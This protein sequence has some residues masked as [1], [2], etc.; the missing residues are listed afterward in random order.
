MKSHRICTH[1]LILT[2]LLTA[3]R[4]LAADA[5]SLELIQTIVLKGKAGK[6]DHLGL[7]ASASGCSWRTP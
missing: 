3:S 6:L 2:C 7:D 5:P 1:G 4:A